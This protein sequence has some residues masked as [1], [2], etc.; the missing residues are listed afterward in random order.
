MKNKPLI[1]TLIVILLII[2]ILLT[3]YLIVGLRTGNIFFYNNYFEV[4]E[5]K[6]IIFD[7]IYKIEDI[8]KLE[9]ISSAGDVNIL[10]STDN[11]I[12]VIVYGRNTD[13]I[14]VSTNNENLK[15]D[16]TGKN[17]FINFGFDIKD[18]DIY[19]PKD[20]SKYM[21]FDLDY[22]DLKIENFENAIVEIK[23]DC[24]DINIGTIKNSTINSSYGDVKIN[25]ILNK[26]DINLSCG[27]VKIENLNINENSLIENDLGDIKIKNTNDIFIDAKV[28]LGDIKVEKNNRTAEIVLK[29]ENSCGDI[30]VNEI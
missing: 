21:K 26:C 11:N 28:D 4:K 15:V 12:R 30:K 7:N 6:N 5:N 19:I 10:E 18:I 27:D 24:G 25:T 16:F 2:A 13:D 20:Y 14:N 17:H 9:V 23:Q 8:E 3:A 22:G 1:I 29:I